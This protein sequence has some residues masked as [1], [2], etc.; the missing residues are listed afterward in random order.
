MIQMTSITLD[1]AAA[2]IKAATSLEALCDALNAFWLACNDDDTYADIENEAK[3]RGID[4]SGLPTFGGAV[5]STS[6]EVWSHD[7]V[8]WLVQGN[9]SEGHFFEIEDRDDLHDLRVD[10]ENIY[11]SGAVAQSIAED[12]TGYRT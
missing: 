4:M 7:A 12:K 10:A 3:A 5:V 9:G 1:A 8:R 6:G 2:R 11:N